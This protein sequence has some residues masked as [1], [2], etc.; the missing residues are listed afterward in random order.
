MNLFISKT[1]IS[2]E[3]SFCNSRE[4]KGIK[5]C[6]NSEVPTQNLLLFLGYTPLTCMMNVCQTYMKIPDVFHTELY[7]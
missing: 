6:K 5:Y 3:L 2:L 7:T 1:K 4:N